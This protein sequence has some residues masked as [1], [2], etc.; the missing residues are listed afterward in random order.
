MQK[1][2]EVIILVQW[3]PLG[4]ARIVD[5]GAWGWVFAEN[6]FVNR[7]GL[8][9]WLK[10]NQN[11]DNNKS[12]STAIK[13]EDAFSF[14][15]S[16][17]SDS[18]I[19]QELIVVSSQISASKQSNGWIAHVVIGYRQDSQGTMKAAESAK[20]FFN[21]LPHVCECYDHERTGPKEY[22]KLYEMLSRACA[23]DEAKY[24]GKIIKDGVLDEWSKRL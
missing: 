18:A 17:A 10:M 5:G 1:L 16:N 8:D 3:L 2:K 7:L 12:T 24:L 22:P 15:L 4:R 9:F 20:S 23:I 14:L 6:W 21:G 13:I 19:G 11:F